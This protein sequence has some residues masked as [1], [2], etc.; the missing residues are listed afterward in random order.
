MQQHITAFVLAFGLL[1]VVSSQA[2]HDERPVRGTVRV[3]RGSDAMPASK[4]PS[5]SG[6]K[7]NAPALSI[8]G[9]MSGRSVVGAAMPDAS[10]KRKVTAAAKR[11]AS[12][13]AK[14]AAR[15]SPDMVGGACV[16]SAWHCKPCTNSPWA[17]T[18][19]GSRDKCPTGD[20]CQRCAFRHESGF[21]HYSWEEYC[22]FAQTDEGKHAIQQYDRAATGGEPDFIQDSVD[23]QMSISYRLERSVLV[24]SSTDYK[25]EMQ[26]PGPGSRGPKTPVVKLPS[27]TISELTDHFV[28]A[29]PER[30]YRR[31][32]ASSEVSDIKRTHRLASSENKYEKQGEQVWRAGMAATAE[33]TAMKAI[34]AP[35]TQ[36]HTVEDHLAE[37]NPDLYRTRFRDE[38][39]DTEAVG[40]GTTLEQAS[41]EAAAS[42]VGLPSH[43]PEAS[44]YKPNK[45]FRSLSSG[46]AA[47][48]SPAA[49]RTRQSQS[50]SALSSR[51]SG[52]PQNPPRP[53]ALSAADS[54]SQ[55]GGSGSV[56]DD[57]NFDDVKFRSMTSA[58]KLVVLKGKI[59]LRDLLQGDKLG[60]SE[61]AAQ[62]YL[63][64]GR[65]ADQ[66][67][68]LLRNYLK[69]VVC[70][71]WQ[72]PA[73]AD[74]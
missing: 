32:I 15:S 63:S 10:K 44:P 13:P 46:L 69:Q 50:S 11:A 67:V 68:K 60:R 52:L 48:A 25:K 27:E 59:S 36:L 53:A 19:S 14:A 33:Q 43:V 21:G 35:T 1:A 74:V 72:G 6:V 41:T 34:L 16:C 66:E 54:I 17:S 23:S 47:T 22:D 73:I 71:V 2:H 56:D 31:L 20:A 5:A 70:G 18:S 7:R 49:G 39:A 64:N 4:V 61:R 24:L 55:V 37:V 62:K 12:A 26:K 30:P 45:L 28:F 42:V 65:L 57:P 40:T 3:S 8:P 38:A 29:D 9:R 51:P 58:Q